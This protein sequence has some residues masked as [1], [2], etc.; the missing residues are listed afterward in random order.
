M[1]IMTTEQIKPLLEKYYDAETTASEEQALK[2]YFQREDVPEDLQADQALFRQLYAPDVIEPY[3]LAT[4]LGQ[5][6]ERWNVLEKTTQRRA[7]VVSMRWIAGVAAC[8][9]VLFSFSSYLNKRPRAASAY[10]TNLKETYDN[11][12]DAAGEAER[13]LT[14]FSIAINKGLD[15][16]NNNATTERQ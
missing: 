14:K 4:R 16:I 13:A 2:E 10:A 1:T 8:M 3:G 7:R 6:I 15:K 12:H 9:L 5:D 11:P